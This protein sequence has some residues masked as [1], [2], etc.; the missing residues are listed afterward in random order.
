MGSTE[1]VGSMQPSPTAVRKA[2]D[3]HLICAL[4]IT[5]CPLFHL[6]EI[7]SILTS[8]VDVH[9]ALHKKLLDRV[10]LPVS[11]LKTP[12]TVLGKWYATGRHHRRSHGAVFTGKTAEKD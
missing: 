8:G 5:L 6:C 3:R 12:T 9:P 10:R 7:G 4:P 2:W 1:G 11:A